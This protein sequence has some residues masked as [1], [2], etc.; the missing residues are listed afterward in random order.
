MKTSFQFQGRL[1]DNYK[2]ATIRP[3]IELLFGP[4]CLQSKCYIELLRALNL[5]IA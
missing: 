4:E 1:N 2:T 3:I 5:T